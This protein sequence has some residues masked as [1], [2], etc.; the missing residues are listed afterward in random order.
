MAK[1]FLSKEDWTQKEDFGI[2][3]SIQR[4]ENFLETVDEKSQKGWET[5]QKILWEAEN[6]QEYWKKPE[7]QKALEALCQEIDV[8]VLDNADLDGMGKKRQA[9]QKFIR[10]D[11]HALPG[12]KVYWDWS[13]SL[14]PYLSELSHEKKE[15]IY[16]EDVLGLFVLL[17]RLILFYREELRRLR[18]ELMEKRIE[19]FNNYKQTP[20]LETVRQIN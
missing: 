16:P 20:T 18:Y 8:R 9:A 5:F 2:S 19:L 1:K 11:F 10:G 15:N 3:M 6:N 7:V 17:D 12:C 4:I 14:D 13:Y